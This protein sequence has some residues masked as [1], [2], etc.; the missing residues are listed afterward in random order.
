MKNIFKLILMILFPGSLLFQYSCS[1]DFL[2][3]EPPGVA[4]GSALESDAGV[5][6]LLIGAYST[7]QGFSRFGGAMGTDWT[8]GSGASDEC[9]KGT[10]SGDQTNFNAVERYECLPSNPYMRDRWRDCY[11]GVS[12]ANQVL[13]FLKTTQAGSSPLTDARAKEVEG[14]A[15]FLRAWFH[16]KA[17]RIFEKI[18]YIKTIDE[19]GG[20][21]PDEIPN[22]SEGWDEIEADLQFAIDNL[23]E[24]YNKQPGRATKYIGMAVKAHAHL[25]QNEHSLAKTLLDAILAS[26]K[27]SLVSNYYDNYDE[28]KENN[29][30]S[31][32]EIQAQT[33]AVNHS[34]LLL[35]GPSMHQVGPAGIGWGFYQ[36]SQ[37][38]FEAFQVTDAGLPVLDINQRV[39]LANDMN[40]E[41]SAEFHPTDH[42]L[43]PRV[44][45]T[46]SRRGIDFLGWGISQGKSWIREQPNGGPYMTKKFMHLAANKGM[47]MYGKGF[48]NNRNFRAYRLAHVILWRAECAIEDGELDKARQLINQVRERAKGSDVVMGLC[49]TYKL[50]KPNAITVDWTKPAAN[51]KVEPYPADSPVF[52]SKEEARKAVRMEIML[53]FATEGHRFFDLRRWGI[54]NEVL[55]DYIARDSKFR[56]FMKGA[57]YNPTEDDYWPI[58]QDQVDIQPSIKQ[59]PAY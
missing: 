48:D 52:A 12:R 30:E 8:Y 6:A 42:L 17:N 4:A 40:V 56:N 58:P 27:Y 25:Y 2:T 53:E 19:M 10:S 18:P 34:A 39:P 15:K 51:Y 24:S 3:K 26:G 57:V 33:S 11:N 32:F 49:T 28:T 54:A 46:I 22:D 20:K 36:P 44:D 9:Y 5:E 14:E 37:T 35:A 59:D 13:K 16:F 21:L 7:L 23:P 47:Q 43:D 31:I 55:N 1:E 38:L 41:S 50:D 45:W 29:K